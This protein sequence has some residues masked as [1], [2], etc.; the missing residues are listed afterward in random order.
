MAAR[1]YAAVVARKA[2]R[3]RLVIRI[4]EASPPEL[5]TTGIHPAERPDL[6]SKRIRLATTWFQKA[7]LA[8]LSIA[9]IWLAYTI[10]RGDA[11]YGLLILALLT[12]FFAFYRRLLWRVRNRLLVTYFLFGV[13]P[14]ILIGLLLF[15]CAQL[16]LAGVAVDR[17]RRDLNARIDAVN[18]AA[19]DLAKAAARGD[20]SGSWED[21]HQRMPEL[22]GSIH[23]KGVVALA[24][25]EDGFPVAASS[26]NPGYHGLFS[27]KGERYI[28]ARAVSDSGDALVY[29]LLD[30][31][32]RLS[33]SPG[34]SVMH[35]V[36]AKDENIDMKFGGSGG[37]IAVGTGAGRTE[38][39]V[40][41]SQS[42]GW[43][44]KPVVG[45]LTQD[46]KTPSGE[47]EEV[48]FPLLSRASH[49][50]ADLE[51][52]RITGVILAV[53]AIIGGFLLII[54]M[55]SLTWS[56]SLTS[57]IT[58]S[59]HD[60]YQGTLQVAAG[61]F[62]HQIPVRGR[63]QLSDLAKSFNGMIS[64]IQHYIGEMRKKE[65]LES[66]LEIARQV[67]NRLFPRAVPEL[68][69]LELAGVCIPGRFVSGDY[70][71]YLQLDARATAIVLGDVSGKGVSAALLMASLQ[72]ALHAQ[73]KFGAGASPAR[74]STDALMAT[75]G[76]Q[77]YENTPPEKY[78][79]MF[80]SIYNDETRTLRYTNAGHLKPI[81]IRDGNASNLEGE[82][83][84]AGLLPGAK[85]EQQEFEIRPGD[86]IAIFSDG[87]PEAEDAQEQDFGEG[88]LAD[89][90][91]Q[92]AAKPLDE[93]IQIILKAV[94]DWAH[95]PDAR[96]DT[97]I[98]LARGR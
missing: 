30:K 58:R 82:G 29:L 22:Q 80:C 62:A 7:A 4:E 43:W 50:T 19:Q 67:Q 17:A 16:I 87:I 52:G 79:T 94:A 83:L 49:L 81:V 15:F 10:Y 35:G 70:Y 36:A 75:V 85:Y 54:E 56:I 34:I 60:L 71:D 33:L 98:V 51:S 65:K 57:T 3:D 84:V 31:K 45:V 40:P 28:A 39:S 37:K 2:R 38:Y 47:T 8:F 11:G 41:V 89:L 42:K 90:L 14:V 72:S 12:C 26:L 93:I 46:S 61:D 59:V 95:D 48:A 20:A 78:A 24:N 92:H 13:V 64:Q 73:L 96:D 23:R 27:W 69:T 5:Y 53:L 55:I 86:L 77:L 9:L 63:H 44:D 25:G 76:Q 91:K 88:R 97:T 68:E 18:T 74:V 66:E 1:A 32:A 6:I 21:I